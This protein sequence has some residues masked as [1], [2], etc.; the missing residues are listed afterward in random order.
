MQ[1]LA[2]TQ[3]HRTLQGGYTNLAQSGS[4]MHL[5]WWSNAFSPTSCLHPCIGRGASMASV[6]RA[7]IPFAAAGI[8]FNVD[9]PKQYV[10]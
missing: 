6:C 1:L 10:F 2:D 8:E 3:V 4:Q 5:A 9:L 7:L